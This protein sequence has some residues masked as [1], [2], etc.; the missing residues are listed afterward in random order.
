MLPGLQQ[1][2]CWLDTPGQT[3]LLDFAHAVR[4][5]LTA[6]AKHLPS[7]FLYDNEG[8]RLFERICEQPEYY[9]TRS[10][11]SLLE[12]H[13]AEI[14]R[15]VPPP[16]LVAE[17]GSG[18][19]LKTRLLLDALFRV[20][21]R[22][23]YM[24]VDLS[25]GAL[26]DAAFHLLR[27]YPRL[28]IL[29]VAGDYDDGLRQTAH[30]HHPQLLLW[31]GS[32]V[33]NFTRTAAAAF[34]GGVHAGMQADDRLLL[35]VD[36]CQDSQLLRRAYDDRAGVT[37]AFHRNLLARINRELGG[38]FDLTA[39]R[40]EATWDADLGR[41][42]MA[43]VSEVDQRIAIDDLEL[44]VVFRKDEEIQT[45]C[46]TKYA[47]RDIDVLAHSA[48]FDVVLQWRDDAR[49]SLVLLAPRGR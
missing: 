48:G 11:L 16:A 18:T 27:D 1:R 30:E 40:Y 5:G 24:P 21:W 6:T 2:L 31:L 7:K 39:F 43:L 25:R 41:M 42:D 32:N 28:D 9:L 22:L 47:R 45:E 37:A 29:A 19:S 23:R 49:M 35:G 8:S 10:E 34:L 20:R 4:E 13:A 17:L 46:S 44:T 3:L 15:A 12:E 14:A 36:T 26:R 38:H 33:G